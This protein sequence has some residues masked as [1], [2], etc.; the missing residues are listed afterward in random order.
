MYEFVFQSKMITATAG[1]LALVFACTLVARP[2]FW[3][4]A[5]AFNFG[6]AFA[7]GFMLAILLSDQMFSTVDVLASLLFEFL[8]L[9]IFCRLVFLSYHALHQISSKTVVQ[10]LTF[11]TMI[12]AILFLPAILSSG[13]G[14]YSSGTRIDYLYDSRAAKYFTYAGMLLAAVMSGLLARRI[15]LNGKPRAGD[16]AIILIFSATSILSGSKGGFVLWIITILALIDYE[17]AKIKTITVALAFIGMLSLVMILAIVVSDFLGISMEDFF[18]L[19]FSRFFLNNDARAMA[20]DLRPLQVP[21]GVGLLNESFRSLSSLFGSPPR[22]LPLGVELY[23]S[24]F[25]PSGGAGANASFV[26]LAIYY[27]APG[28][29]VLPLLVA[30]LG[31]LLLFHLQT[32]AVR[33]MSTAFSRFALLSVS[34]V[35]FSL[36][37][38]DFL[39]FQLVA[40]LTVVLILTFLILRSFHAFVFFQPRTGAR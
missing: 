25:G 37:S 40:P 30:A 5:L 1:V 22:N 15:T 38:Q 23:D 8:I 26:A 11:C 28:L 17:K 39:A 32:L 34:A 9:C 4:R 29:A 12:Y 13:F 7:V 6:P 27:T 21:S 24:Y 14:I 33:A 20:F 19:A 31:A 16:Y 35:V 10:A 2:G 36:L 3:W 18:N